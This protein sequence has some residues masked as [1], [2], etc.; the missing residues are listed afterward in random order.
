MQNN[1]IFKYDL[2]EELDN[3][4]VKNGILKER[5][6]ILPPYEPNQY[7]FVILKKEEPRIKFKIEIYPQEIEEPHFLIRYQNE[8]CRFKIIDGSPYL[9]KNQKIPNHIKKIL[10]EINETYLKHKDKIQEEWNKTRNSFTPPQSILSNYQK[11][12]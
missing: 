4:L 11:T 2:S 10:K 1:N 7:S 3:L 8:T 5:G 6:M 12:K 9:G